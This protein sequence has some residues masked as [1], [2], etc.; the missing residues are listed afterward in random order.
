MGFDFYYDRQLLPNTHGELQFKVMKKLKLN[1]F[2]IVILMLFVIT[3]GGRR[4]VMRN[5]LEEL[6]ATIEKLKAQKDLQERIDGLLVLLNKSEADLRGHIITRDEQFLSG[7]D[8]RIETIN[9]SFDN[10][11]TLAVTQRILT[12]KD[13]TKIDSLLRTKIEFINYIKDLCADN[14]FEEAISLIKTGNGRVLTDSLNS[15]FKRSGSELKV[16]I[17]S[18]E[19][20]YIHKSSEENLFSLISFIGLMILLC[21]FLILLYFT[22]QKNEKIKTQLA[23]REEKLSVTLQGIADGVLTTDEKGHVNYLN[24]VAET[25]L[26]RK[27]DDVAGEHIKQVFTISDEDSREPIEAIFDQVILNGQKLE[28]RNHTV[29][30]GPDQEYIIENSAAPLFNHSK[31]IIGMVIVFRNVTERKKNELALIEAEKKFRTIFEN[32][33]EGIYRSTLKGQLVLVNPS[34]V[35]MFEYESEQQMLEN[36]HH[37]GQQLYVNQSDRDNVISQ[38]KKEGIIREYEFQ[39]R[40]F[41]GKTIWIIVNA[42]NVYDENGEIVCVEGTTT[43]ITQRKLDQERLRNQFDILNRYAFINSHEVRAHVA[44]MLGL[45]NLN[46]SQFLTEEERKQVLQHLFDETNKLD[47]VIRNLSELIGSGDT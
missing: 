32:T 23:E 44:T 7:F 4:L 28:T 18:T 26:S 35:K 5:Q 15:M 36:I 11:M 30:H 14:R 10:F 38:L 31:E 22:I 46:F 9:S 12:S 45:M 34:M 1:V 33:R 43:D 47:L 29:L 20:D 42:H 27:L 41:T 39:A 24:P 17:E 3:L 19:S 21:G 40:T 16:L 8:E 25:L 37:I 2:A 13:T 6:R